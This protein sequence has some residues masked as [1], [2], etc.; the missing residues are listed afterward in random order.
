LAPKKWECIIRTVPGTRCE[1][2]QEKRVDL[3]RRWFVT[4]S[5]ISF[6]AWVLYWLPG[7]CRATLKTV[8]RCVGLSNEEKR[9][10]LLGESYRFIGQCKEAIPEDANILFLTNKDNIDV[11]FG[12]HLFPRRIYL[13]D[14]TPLRPKIPPRTAELD[15]NSLRRR[16]IE[17]VVLEYSH[18][19]SLRRIVKLPA[20]GEPVH[21]DF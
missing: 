16:R 1:Q 9:A 17:W 14:T 4:L 19:H 2:E 3:L 7:E 20:Q 10:I 8:A 21:T 13:R 5:L 15:L 12:Y 18:T 11:F 6:F